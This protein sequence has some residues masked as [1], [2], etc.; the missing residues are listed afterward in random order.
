MKTLMNRRIALAGVLACTLAAPLRADL[1]TNGGFES[2]FTGWTRV[3]QFG[4]DGTFAAQTGTVSPVNGF[5][6]PSPPQGTTAAMTDSLGPGSH[7]LYQNFTVGSPQAVATVSFWLYLNNDHGA[8]DF[9]VPGALTSL[10]FS[11]PALNQQARVDIT[12][13]S[14]D[15]FSIAAGDVLQNLFSTLPGDPLVAGYNQFQADITA[16]YNAHTGETLRLRFAEVDNV[17]PFNMGVDAVDVAA[18]D[19][20]AVPEPATWMMMA[21]V[22]LGTGLSRRRHRGLKPTPPVPKDA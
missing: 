20:A 22:I 18:V 13:I 12:T 11:T 16:L 10:D 2:G 6:V 1:L 21:G 5:P 8:P 19:V 9:F 3:D 7:V 4:G 15:P 14:A 17:A